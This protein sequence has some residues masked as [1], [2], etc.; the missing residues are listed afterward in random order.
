MNYIIPLLMI[1]PGVYEEPMHLADSMSRQKYVKPV[2]RY[3]Q[4]SITYDELLDQAVV[5]CKN[6]KPENIDYDLLDKL[7]EIEKKYSPPPEL[8]GMILAAA[9]QESGF[10]PKARGDHKFSKSGKKPLAHGLFQMWPWWENPK[11]YAVDRDDPIQS[12]EAWIKHITKQIKHIKRTCNYKT[13]K[14]IWIAAWVRAI[15]APKE[16]GRC[17]EVPRHYRLL[18]RWHK[19]IL[20]IKKIKKECEIDGCGC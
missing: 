12:A 18:K 7:V 13:Q 14:R 17:L 9:C 19:N 3:D 11:G 16:G 6:A 20:H 2:I 5:N 4:A 1:I 15:R 8:R 10:N